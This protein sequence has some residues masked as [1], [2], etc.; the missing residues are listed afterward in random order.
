MSR[1]QPCACR[2][3]DVVIHVG[4]EIGDAHDLPFDGARAPRGIHA[5]R[6]ARLPLRMLGDAV[7]HFPREVQAAAVVLER[8]D[9]AQAL[10]VVIEAARHEPI[11]DA[12]AGVT[13][14]R[15]TEIVAERDRFGQLLV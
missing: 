2:I 10:L 12:L 4:D 7:A 11:D 13:E 5:D 14:R 8:V 1:Q 15:V 3:V 6:C 9:D